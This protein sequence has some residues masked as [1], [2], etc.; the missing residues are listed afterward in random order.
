MVPHSLSY[1]NSK[2]EEYLK[3]ISIYADGR[4]IGHNFAGRKRILA[5]PQKPAVKVLPREGLLQGINSPQTS[6]DCRTSCHGQQ[7]PPTAPQLRHQRL[8]VDNNQGLEQAS[9]SAE[10]LI[11]TRFRTHDGT[12]TPPKRPVGSLSS[13]SPHSPGQLP[14]QSFKY[15]QPPPCTYGCSVAVSDS[16]PF[17]AGQAKVQRVCH[18]SRHLAADVKGQRRYQQGFMKDSRQERANCRKRLPRPQHR[19]AKRISSPTAVSAR[20]Y[21]WYCGATRGRKRG[22]PQA[23]GA[24][25][26][27]QRPESAHRALQKVMSVTSRR[28]P[29]DNM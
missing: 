19:A 14:E 24:Y 21:F 5:L 8:P 12:A 27:L 23:V 26:T 11:R 28:H 6:A 25:R 13:S 16:L 15:K 4:Q 22:H 2:L 10:L 3:F 7:R 29:K 9:H 20:T 17:F 18:R 1:A